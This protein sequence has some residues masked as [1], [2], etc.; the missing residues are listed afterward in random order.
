MSRGLR[1][2]SSAEAASGALNDPALLDVVRLRRD[3][4]ANDLPAGA[5]GVVVEVFEKPWPAVMVEFVDPATGQTSADP[6]LPMDAVEVV[7]RHA[8]EA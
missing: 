1:R 7:L 2:S 5:E 3:F 4:P 8:A 6:I